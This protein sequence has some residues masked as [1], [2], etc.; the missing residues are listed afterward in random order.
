MVLKIIQPGQYSNLMKIIYFIL[1]VFAGLF[2]LQVHAQDTATAAFKPSIKFK[3]QIFGDFEYRP[4]SDSLLRGITQYAGVSYPSPINYSSFDI[5]RIYLGAD[6]VFSKHVFGSI[7]LANEG[8]VDNQRN[9]VFSIKESYIGW[10]DLYK[11][12]DI[13]IGRSTTPAFALLTERVWGYRSDEKTIGDMRSI[14]TAVDLGVALRG[15][16]NNAGTAGY[17]FMIGNGS[18]GT[19]PNGQKAEDDMFKKFYGD[20]WAKIFDKKIVLDLYA[21][22]ERQQ[23]TDLATGRPF[24]KSKNAF[25][26]FI[27]YQTDLITVG[28]EAFIQTNQNFS[29]FTKPGSTIADTANAYTAGLS[30]YIHGRIIKNKLGYFARYDAFNPDLNFNH[31]YIY[32]TGNITYTENFMTAGLDWMPAKDLHIMPNIWVD[33]YH[34]QVAK[35]G[36]AKNDYDMSLRLTFYFVFQQE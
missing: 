13:L 6:F 15:R 18:V 5:R 26:G 28:V 22:Y 1:C 24:H 3:G 2:C 4:H 27:A 7:L 12:A 17:N 10:K 35:E 31:T 19:V 20:V 30:A 11:N 16:F 21:D 25:K 23:L 34:D 32:Q 9:P 29:I 14:A 8:N 36:K 33:S